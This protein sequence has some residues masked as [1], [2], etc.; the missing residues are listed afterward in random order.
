MR[1]SEMD[2]LVRDIVST[3]KGSGITVARMIDW[4]KGASDS[5]IVRIVKQKGFTGE[6]VADFLGKGALSKGDVWS[7]TREQK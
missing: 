1:Q 4:S 7:I 2:Q 6:Q 3:L 5:G